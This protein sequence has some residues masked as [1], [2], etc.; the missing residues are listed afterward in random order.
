[1]NY[2]EFKNKLLFLNLR[3][4][5]SG[6][7]T[8]DKSI[9]NTIKAVVLDMDGVLVDTEPIHMKSFAIYLDKRGLF[10]DNEFLQSLIGY[11][12]ADNI[13][14]IHRKF[15]K[16]QIIDLENDVRERDR[17]YV[18]LLRQSDLQPMKGIESLVNTCIKKGLKMALASSSDLEQV[19][20]IIDSLSDMNL[21]SKLSS[22]VSGNDVSH[23]KP[24]PAI[25]IKTLE[26]LELR[27]NQCLAVEDSDAGVSSAKA[28]GLYCLAVKNPFTQVHIH[29]QA[30]GILTDVDD[31]AVIIKSL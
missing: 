31:L 25:Y 26:N 16:E 27:G 8:I 15:Y 23:R 10:Y 24:N 18:D 5:V 22:I 4:I 28:A 7:T 13:R 6:F 12:I 9:W 3:E 20:I 17:I 14:M 19:D 29:P 11:S 21:R 2:N 30:D 1:M